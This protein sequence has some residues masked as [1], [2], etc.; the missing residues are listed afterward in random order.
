MHYSKRLARGFCLSGMPWQRSTCR[1]HTC[2]DPAEGHVNETVSSRTTNTLTGRKIKERPIKN[3][4]RMLLLMT[5]CSEWEGVCCVACVQ[6][7]PS[8]E[9]ERERERA[10]N[11]NGLVGYSGEK[12]VLQCAW[13]HTHT[14]THISHCTH[15]TLSLKQLLPLIWE[16]TSLSTGPDIDPCGREGQV[17]LARIHITSSGTIAKWQSR[18]AHYLLN[19]SQM[20]GLSSALFIT[21]PT[22]GQCQMSEGIHIPWKLLRVI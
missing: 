2:A 16:T 13:A 19:H 14:H 8:Y 22:L 1:V 10:G 9:R 6:Y 21:V 4:D 15:H 12:A 20:T 7:W 3:Y 17:T 5:T 18:L 11:H